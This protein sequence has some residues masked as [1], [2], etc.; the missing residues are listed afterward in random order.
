MTVIEKQVGC[1]SITNELARPALNFTI[2]L[3][4]SLRKNYRANNIDSF[5]L[6]GEFFFIW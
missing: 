3:D 1:Y 6:R 4:G 5:I 2:Q